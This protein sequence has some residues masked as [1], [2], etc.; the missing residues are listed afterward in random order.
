MIGRCMKHQRQVG[1]HIGYL[2]DHDPINGLYES[3]IT[4]LTD[5]SIKSSNDLYLQCC[6]AIKED[7]WLA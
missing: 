5:I 3:S 2:K 7:I 6:I 4:R 1:I